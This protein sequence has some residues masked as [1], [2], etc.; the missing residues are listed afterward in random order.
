MWP[1]PPDDRVDRS[2]S[3]AI[4]AS[5]AEAAGAASKQPGRAAVPP[6]KIAARGRPRRFA[7]REKISA[8]STR[9]RGEEHPGVI[10]P[11]RKIVLEVRHPVPVEMRHRPDANRRRRDP[12]QADPSRWRTEAAPS[13]LCDSLFRAGA[14]VYAGRAPGRTQAGGRPSPRP[15]PGVRA[16]A[17][18]AKGRPTAARQGLGPDAN[19]SLGISRGAAPDRRKPAVP[20]SAPG[21]ADS[22]LRPRAENIPK[23]SPAGK[24]AVK[25]G[26]RVAVRG[27]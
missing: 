1:A 3:T 21:S 19:S 8:S 15:G 6:T 9:P 23:S 14:G 11:D 12:H 18:L 7:P 26:D 5:A 22:G 27:W 20:A 24:V 2:V 4:E 16:A 10:A 25:R 17:S 13:R